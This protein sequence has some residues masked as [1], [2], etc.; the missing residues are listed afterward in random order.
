MDV[1]AQ[2]RL[3]STCTSSTVPK[4]RMLSTDLVLVHGDGAFARG[5]ARGS[6]GVFCVVVSFGAPPPTPAPLTPSPP[7]PQPTT[8]AEITA[9]NHS[10][11]AER[12]MDFP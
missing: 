7:P 5:G 3:F 8:M 10:A 11:T 12:F 2:R 6:A 9:S 1:L 4:W